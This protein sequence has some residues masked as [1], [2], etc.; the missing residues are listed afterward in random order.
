MVTSA[1]PDQPGPLLASGGSAH[2][3]AWG[4]QHVL[5]LYFAGAPAELPAAEAVR[6]NAARAAGAAAPLAVQTVNVSG[7]NGILFERIAGPTML[8]ALLVRPDM[9]HALAERLAAMQAGLHGLAGNGLPPLD[10]RVRERIG[11]CGA[12]PATRRAQLA[13]LTDRLRPGT[14][15]CHGDFHPGN[16]ILAERGPVIIDWYDATSGA[17]DADFACTLL[18]L[19]YA[20][21]PGAAGPAVEQ[22][23]SAFH[24]AYERAYRALRPVAAASLAAWTLVMAAARLA[25]APTRVERERLADLIERGLRA[26]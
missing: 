1:S 18:R 5:K 22:V 20:S 24:D 9:L 6:T 15:L 16:V 11:H 14:A 25:E 13:A 21:V 17:P 12:L 2:V 23:R 4:A 19:R 7:R 3:H 8:E 26:A 10:Q